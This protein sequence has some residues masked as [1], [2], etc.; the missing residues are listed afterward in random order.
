MQLTLKDP[1]E[2]ISIEK[3]SPSQEGVTLHVHADADK[4]K[5]G[6]KGNLI[7]DVFVERTMNPEK[8]K[9]QNNQKT[10]SLGHVAGHPL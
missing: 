10:H 2:G 7:V 6:P 8:G 1:P 5:P 9:P 4:V 3:I